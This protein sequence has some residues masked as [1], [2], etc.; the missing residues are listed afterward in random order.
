M[1]S[2]FPTISELKQFIYEKKR[3]TICEIRDKFSQR[4]NSTICIKNSDCNKK[5][6]VLAY[7]INK[8]FWDFLKIFMKKAYV[9]CDIDIMVCMYSDKTIYSGSNEFVPLVLSIDM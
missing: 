5:D 3:A 2:Q 6:L 9:R 1:K 8:E 4:G 7:N